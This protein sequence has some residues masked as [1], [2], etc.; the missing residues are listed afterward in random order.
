MFLLAGFVYL[1]WANVL[2]APER[3]ARVFPSPNGYDACVLAVAK[4][5]AAPSTGAPWD[6]DLHALRSDVA[7]ARPGLA[8]LSA[9]VRLPYLSPVRDPSSVGPFAQYR[10]ASRQ[11]AGQARVE[12]ADGRPGR[13]L[14]RSLDVIELGAKM[15]RGG[16]VIDSL[17]GAACV[18]IGQ[19]AAE[20]CVSRLSAAEARAAGRRL[21]GILAQLPAPADVLDE[22]RR[23]S[24]GWVRN[25]LSGRAPIASS[26]VNFGNSA[27]WI[28]HVKERALLLVYP[29]SWG[30][31]QVDRYWR[32]LGTELRKPYAQ[33]KQPS[34]SPPEW[35]PVLGGDSMGLSSLQF[36]FARTQA[37]L[38]L[39][40]VELALHAYRSQHAAYPA[41]L[42][43]LVPSEVAA[44]PV[45]PFSEQPLRYRRE[46]S[47]YV[48]YS[49]GPDLKDDQGAPTDASRGVNAGSTGDLVAGKLFPSRSRTAPPVLR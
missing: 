34:L 9:A 12:L 14:E 23:H 10:E 26:P 19:N 8:A 2:P 37:S 47:A 35:D 11:L 41:T 49:V 24:L 39:L 32:A 3:D 46:G 48:L 36:P 29:K 20:R 25:T 5:P 16:P 21:D 43:Q 15:G 27:T 17:V 18:A 31:Y 44:V 40:R 33:R 28:D 7:Q 45:D 6:S 13:A 30:Y 42:E 1:A 4:L 22:E 38:R